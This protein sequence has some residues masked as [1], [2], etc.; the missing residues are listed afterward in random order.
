MS[1]RPETQPSILVHLLG[2][3]LPGVTVSLPREKQARQ[4]VDSS[5]RFHQQDCGVWLGEG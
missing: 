4:E 1:P 5:I 3:P 2:G